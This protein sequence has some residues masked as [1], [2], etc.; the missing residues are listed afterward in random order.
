MWRFLLI[1]AVFVS[2]SFVSAIRSGAKAGDF[3]AIAYSTNSGAWGGSSNY[4]SRDAA[5]Q[6]ALSEC[7]GCQVVAWFQNTCA[8]LAATADHGYGWAWNDDLITAQNEAMSRC[9][10]YGSCSLTVWVCSR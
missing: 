3:G 2:M 4:E 6:A 10:N 8:A 9:S 5:E 1:G 7:D